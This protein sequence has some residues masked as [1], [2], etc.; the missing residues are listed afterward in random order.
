MISA[1]VP[2]RLRISV[3]DIVMQEEP[4]KDSV[5]G[6][7]TIEAVCRAGECQYNPVTGELLLVK[8]DAQGAVVT[9]LTGPD[10]YRLER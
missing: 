9:Q 5:D 2:F 7:C 1:S 6:L 3:Q 4:R 8:L 10:A